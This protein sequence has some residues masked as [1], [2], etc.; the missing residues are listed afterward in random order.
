M[1]RTRGRIAPKEGEGVGGPQCGKI[2][3]SKTLSVLDVRTA[4]KIY[5]SVP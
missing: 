5:E 1:K 2:L 3:K 4:F